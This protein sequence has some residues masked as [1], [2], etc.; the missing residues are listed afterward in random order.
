MQRLLIV[1]A[2]DFGLSRGQ[3]YGIVEACRNGVVTSTTAL[4]NGAAV[5]HAVALRAQIPALAVG[6]HF[7]LTL[8]KPVGNTPSLTREGLLGNGSGIWLR[9]VRCRWRRLPMSWPASMRALLRCLASHRHIS[10]VIIMCI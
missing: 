5:D 3:N 6:L 7:T 10:T 2:D 4:V 9:K 8:G 1:N